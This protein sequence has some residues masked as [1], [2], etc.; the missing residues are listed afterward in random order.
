M[1]RPPSSWPSPPGRGGI[2]RRVF[3]E[4]RIK[5]RFPIF[6]FCGVGRRWQGWEIRT[7]G[8]GGSAGFGL[9]AGVGRL[10]SPPR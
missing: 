8:L 10:C 2:L 4:T 9:V 1:K 5:A 6:G 3:K 7:G